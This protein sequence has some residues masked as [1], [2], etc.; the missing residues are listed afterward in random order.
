[1]NNLDVELAMLFKDTDSLGLSRMSGQDGFYAK[2]GENLS[3][4]FGGPIIF[5]EF[6]EVVSP[7]AGL[8]EGAI[9]RS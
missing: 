4:L 1:M 7:E 2:A 9:D 3:N 6:A 8:V 5:T